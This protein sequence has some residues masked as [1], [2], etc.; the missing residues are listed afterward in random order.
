MNAR[1][2]LA[3]ALSTLSGCVLVALRPMVDAECP[4]PADYDASGNLV[5][6]SCASAEQ[7][8]H[9]L[10]M[11]KADADLDLRTREAYRALEAR[12]KQ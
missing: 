9:A 5:R 7:W 12:G 3:L 10:D 1:W 8:Q 11:D 6:T 2:L 4:L